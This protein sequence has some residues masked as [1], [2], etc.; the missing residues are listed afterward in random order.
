MSTA[1]VAGNRSGLVFEDEEVC[2][3]FPK[4]DEL[5]GRDFSLEQ[6]LKD[7]ERIVA[8][9]REQADD[10]ALTSHVPQEGAGPAGRGRPRHQRR[11]DAAPGGRPRAQA[12]A[13]RRAGARGHGARRCTGAGPTRTRTP[14]ASASRCSPPPRACATPSCGPPSSRARSTSPSPGGTRASPPRRRWPSPASRASAASPPG[15]RTILDIIPVD[16]VA[17]ATIGITAH[18]L[19][20]EERRVYQLASGDVNPFYASRSVELVGLYRRRYYRNKETGNALLNAVRSRVEPVAGQPRRSSSASAR[21]PSSRAPRLL[22]KAID[23]VRPTWG[24]PAVQALLDRAK[25]KLDDVEE[26]ASE[27][28]E[29]DRAVPALHL[30]EPLRV[31]LRQHALGVRAH[32][33]R[34]PAEDPL[35]PGAHRLARLL[36]G[37]APARPGEV[38]VPGPGGGDAE[39]HRHPRA[40]RSA[41]AV[42]GLRA[43]LPAPRGLPH[44]RRA[45]RRSA[46]PTARCTATPARGQRPAAAR[47]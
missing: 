41:R 46:S 39:A 7:A 21:R 45:R 18:A 38:G 20:V 43:R 44:V 15:E 32:G 24:A 33:A 12:V 17:G 40:P 9:L 28:R 10:K 6:E 14:R 11:E 42:R 8:R 31:P 19:T 1:F 16:H 3:Y 25:E 2:G 47:A 30:G 23:E 35:G 34:G 36:A 29:P 27:P 26:Q 5:D 13:H 37:D 4:K 22:K